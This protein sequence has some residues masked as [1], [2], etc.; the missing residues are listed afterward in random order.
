MFPSPPANTNLIFLEDESDYV[1]MPPSDK[2]FYSPSIPAAKILPS[3]FHSG[4]LIILIDGKLD[5]DIERDLW[6]T[7]RDL[8]TDKLI[9]DIQLGLMDKRL[10]LQVE[11]MFCLLS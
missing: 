3:A 9:L 8:D 5:E 11:I 4:D 6:I 7:I 1:L 2:I 10:L